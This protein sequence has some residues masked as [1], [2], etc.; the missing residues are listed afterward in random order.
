M[1]ETDLYPLLKKYLEEK[2]FFV[3]AE[4][5]NVD[6]VAKKDDLI[7][8]VEMKTQLNL[9]LIYQ[10]CQRQKINDNVYLAVPRINNKKT[11]KERLHILRRLNLGLLIVDLKNETVESAIDPKEF[12]FRRSKNKKQKLLKEMD[13]R[14]TN[15]NIGGTTKKKLVTSYREKA[16]KIA[17]YLLNGEKTT[18]ELRELSGI[19]NSTQFLQKNYYKWFYRVSRGVYALTDRGSIDLEKYKD[20]FIELKLKE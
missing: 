7:V 12:I 14:I 6:I 18:K 10:G 17:Y 8:I 2:G 20:L 19:E 9:K 5:N 1:R 15:I 16:I 13:Q 11:Y 3:Q 4:V